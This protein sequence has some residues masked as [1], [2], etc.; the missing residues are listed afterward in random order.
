[1]KSDVE[2]LIQKWHSLSAEERQTV[3]K[4]PGSSFLMDWFIQRVNKI[5]KDEPTLNQLV[6]FN[7]FLPE[8]KPK[9]GRLNVV[10]YFKGILLKP[11]TQKVITGLCIIA[12]FSAL[13][14]LRCFKREATLKNIYSLLTLMRNMANVLYPL[15]TE[16][17]M[18]TELKT[19]IDF[20]KNAP[21]LVFILPS[22]FFDYLFQ[23]KFIKLIPISELPKKI[24]IAEDEEE[25]NEEFSYNVQI[26]FNIEDFYNHLLPTNNLPN[27]VKPADWYFDENKNFILTNGKDTSFSKSH[28]YHQHKAEIKKPTNSKQA[29]ANSLIQYINHLQ[30]QQFVIYSDMKKLYSY[31]A[32]EGKAHP[33]YDYIF[34][35][36]IKVKR[37]IGSKKGTLS[38]F[39]F[40]Q[41]TTSDYH[42]LILFICDLIGDFEIYFTFEI[43]FR[44]RKYQKGEPNLLGDNFSRALIQ[45]KQSYTLTGEGVKAFLIQ[46]SIFFLNAPRTEEAQIDFIWSKREFFLEL[47]KTKFSLIRTILYE[48]KPK[49]IFS[50]IN[51]VYHGQRLF[52]KPTLMAAYSNKE[53]SNYML[54]LDATASSLQHI[55][56]LT[57]SQFYE[58]LNMIPEKPKA[59]I[60]QKMQSLIEEILLSDYSITVKLSRKL[61]KELIMTISYGA[62]HISC[63]RKIKNYLRSQKLVKKLKALT[64]IVYNA[65]ISMLQKHY[66]NFL[67]LINGLEAIVSWRNLYDTEYKSSGEIS[68]SL[69]DKNFHICQKYM[70]PRVKRHKITFKSIKKPITFVF[71][72][73]GNTRN[74]QKSRRALTANLIHSFDAAIMRLSFKHALKLNVIN[75]YGDIHDCILTDCNS[76]L[77]INQAYALALKEFYT[78]NNMRFLWKQLF[79]NSLYEALKAGKIEKNIDNQSLYDLFN[80]AF[81]RENA[82]IRETILSS[83]SSCKYLLS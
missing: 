43:D 47:I 35:P 40:T 12:F 13:Y 82:R 51:W 70:Y 21:D 54:R 58:D 78:T 8:N 17:F 83:I 37:K 24:P 57:A 16:R 65:V 63:K 55:N 23:E 48:L 25:V 41:E 30:S 71:L 59:D 53:K 20:V 36:A 39:R 5:V 2:L 15:I 27:F 29:Q 28:L 79:G 72:E 9:I 38:R 73:K 14:N 45:P 49:E 11:E 34:P 64:I 31:V 68:W 26:L 18:E 1:M 62:Q 75:F 32:A 52:Q 76:K 81:N 67:T 4:A 6:H 61:V 60:Y 77:Q 56:L 33:L 46:G 66:S 74:V 50:F 22:I 80:M 10:P 42:K 19:D 69:E 44:F 3:I 7:K